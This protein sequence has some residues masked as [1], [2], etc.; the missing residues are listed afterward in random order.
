MARTLL[1]QQI[2]PETLSNLNLA[3]IVAEKGIGKTSLQIFT[4]DEPK[5]D[6]PDKTMNTPILTN[7]D[8]DS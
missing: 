6:P 2:F 1:S 3:D 7:G 5:V 8:E 4:M